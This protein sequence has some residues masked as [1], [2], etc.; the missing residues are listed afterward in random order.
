M[1]TS[2]LVISTDPIPVSSGT[3][4]PAQ[5]FCIDSADRANWLVRRIVAARAYRERVRVWAE[6]EERRAILE[7]RELLHRFGPQLQRWIISEIAK[8]NGRRKSVSLPA[9]T[10][11][12]RQIGTRLL[13]D[14]ATAA[15]DWARINCPQAVVT[16][17]ILSKSTLKEHMFATGEVPDV[18]I[19]LEPSRESFFVR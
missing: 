18:G 9:G 10:A 12:F 3:R 6:A 11:G 17:Q 4:G 14:D 2:G 16:R 15:L 5:E 13:I 8:S 1:G 19:S 7:E